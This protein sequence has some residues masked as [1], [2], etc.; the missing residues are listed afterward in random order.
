MNINTL[1]IMSIVVGVSG[2]LL[3]GEI[4]SGSLILGAVAVMMI[5]IGG[6]LSGVAHEKRN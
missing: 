5:W 2:G 3:I 4:F 6:F 1:E